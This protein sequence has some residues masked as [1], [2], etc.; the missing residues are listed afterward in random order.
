MKFFLLL[1]FLL[2][3]SGAATCQT[4]VN[5][6]LPKAEEIERVEISVQ[7]WINWYQPVELLKLLPKFVAKEGT[8]LTKQ[9]FQRG[10]FVLKNG[11]RIEWMANSNRSILLYEETARDRKEQL[12]V[13]P[14][15]ET[16]PPFPIFDE[17]GDT[18]FIDASGKVVIQPHPGANSSEKTNRQR[19]VKTVEDFSEGLALRFDADKRARFVNERG[20]EVFRLAPDIKTD[21]SYYTAQGYEDRSAA[22]SSRFS[23][24]LVLVYKQVAGR[25]LFG[26]LDRAGKTA[27]DFRFD[28]AT[29]FSDGLAG[30]V[31]RE[32]D[33]LFKGYINPQGEF[34]LRNTADIAPFYNGLAFHLLKIRTISQKPDFR[35]IYGYMNKQGKYVWLSPDAENSMGKAWY[36]ENFVGAR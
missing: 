28:D 25:K 35:N 36:K 14:E 21:A 7:S 15:Q 2:L 31:I 8:Y 30:V 34:V 16:K 17:K 22:Y 10:T 33:K 6:N 18:G 4:S 13:L 27:I 24:G 32:P 20:E 1:I 9:P 29:P 3:F 11:K 26:Y 5:L 12:F 19:I 23:H